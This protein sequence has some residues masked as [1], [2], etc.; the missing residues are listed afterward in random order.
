[1]RELDISVDMAQLSVNKQEAAH[2]S[3]FVAGWR[4]FTGWATGLCFVG[5]V[6][7]GVWGFVTGQDMTPLAVLYGAT[8]APVQ[9]G[10]L[11]LRS[12]EKAKGIDRQALSHERS[13]KERVEPIWGR[14]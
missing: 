12:Y 1:M 4:P 11:G 6:A 13:A 5:V 8:V 14:L 3:I 10:M 9:M 7:I 2:A